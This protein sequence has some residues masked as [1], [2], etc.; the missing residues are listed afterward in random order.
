MFII[1]IN[2]HVLLN[3]I[4]YINIWFFSKIFIKS[5]NGLVLVKS[6]KYNVGF[7]TGKHLIF[8]LYDTLVP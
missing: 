2:N 5:I 3:A 7:I 1:S 6:I 4:Q 8:E